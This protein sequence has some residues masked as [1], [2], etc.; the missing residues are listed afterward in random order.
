VLGPKLGKELAGVRAAL[1]AGDFEELDA[2]RFRVNGHDLGP[3]EVLVERR[4]RE[5]WAVAVEDGITVALDT[6][7]D[8]ELELEGR[9]FDLIHLL[10]SMRKDGGFELT[11]RVRVRLPASYRELE[12][13]FDWIAREVLAKEIVIDDAAREPQIAKA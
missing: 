2:G 4:G 1:Q 13:H 5:G 11:D 7:V 3:D 12:P 6:S 9:A 10:N 8:E